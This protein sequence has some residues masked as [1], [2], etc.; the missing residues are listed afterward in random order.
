[1]EHMKK[2][3]WIVWRSHEN[4]YEKEELEKRTLTKK[5][6]FL[7]SSEIEDADRDCF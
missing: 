6:S 2:A 3:Y 1:M 4:G 7:K 5:E